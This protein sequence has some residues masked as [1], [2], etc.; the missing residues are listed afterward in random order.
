MSPRRDQPQNR[1]YHQRCQPSIQRARP[2]LPSRLRSTQGAHLRHRQP[3]G[4]STSRKPARDRSQ[5]CAQTPRPRERQI[6]PP[7]SPS[8]RKHRH[9]KELPQPL[10]RH[11]QNGR[12]VRHAH[13]LQL[14]PPQPQPPR[15]L[16]L[17]TRPACAGT[18]APRLP[19]LQLSAD[20]RLLRGERQRHPP[21]GKQLLR[22]HRQT[23]LRRVHPHQ[24]RAS[25]SPRQSLLHPQ[26]H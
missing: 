18:A 4:R 14:S 1:R 9:R 2:P 7:L 10:H 15:S 25:R 21:R 12:E 23:H 26:R 8:R 17:P 16:W 20:A 13:P 22:L 5:R 3:H 6:H 11:Q 24:H 19:R